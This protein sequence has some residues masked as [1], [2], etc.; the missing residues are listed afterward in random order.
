MPKKGTLSAMGR[1]V[2]WPQKTIPVSQGLGSGDGD[3]FVALD[4]FRRLR[5]FGSLELGF[6]S[7]LVNI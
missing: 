2:H 7:P 6:A 3:K 4:S 1:I 5:I